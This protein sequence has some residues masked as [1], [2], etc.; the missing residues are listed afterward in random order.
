MVRKFKKRSRQRK[1]DKLWQNGIRWNDENI[2]DT[3]PS[4]VTIVNVKG[5]VAMILVNPGG[6]QSIEKYTSYGGC[7]LFEV[8]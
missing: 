4:E 7:E 6:E 1:N 3:I 5:N 8:N 2:E